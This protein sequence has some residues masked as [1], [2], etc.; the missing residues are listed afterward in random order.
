MTSVTATPSA[1]KAS[2]IPLASGTRKDCDSFVNGD[3]F[4]K[5]LK[6]TNY[7]SNCELVAAVNDIEFQ[8]L[9]RWNP[10]K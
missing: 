9:Q 1:T 4:Q 8:Y 7:K 5:N 6:G 10:S 3:N 2:S